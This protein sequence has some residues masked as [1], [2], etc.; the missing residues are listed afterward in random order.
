MRNASLALFALIFPASAVEIRVASFNIGA[1]FGTT[2]FDYSLGDAGTPD[3]DAVR[4]ILGRINADV[5]ALQEIHT[6]DLQGSPDDLDD[7]AAALGYPYLHVT[8][9]T[10]AFDPSLRVV[11]MSRFPFITEADIVSP[12]GARELS[13]LHPVVKVDVPGTT[14]DLVVVS[15]H[16][17]AE[18]SLADRFRRAVEMKRLVAYLGSAGLANDD[19]FVIVGDFNPSSINATFTGL[20][21][22]LPGG[23]VLGSDI[24]FPVSYSTNPLTYFSTPGAVRLDLRQLDGSKSTYGTTS[25]N[26]PALDMILVSPAIAGRL[27]AA[28]VYNSALD[29]GNETGLVKAGSPLAAATS[30]TASDHYA[31]FADLELDSDSPNLDLTISAPSV[32]EG[33]ADGTV[34]ATVTIPAPRPNAVVV[35]LS[36]DDATAAAP[37]AGTLVIPAGAVGGSV[38][39]ATPRNFIADPQRSVTITATA[40]GY[41]PDSAVLQVDDVDG[42]Y[43]FTLPGQ[44]VVENFNGFAGDHEPAPWVTSG[45]LT[46]RG[47]DDGSSA[48][49]GLRAYGA[50][51]DSSLGW[52]PQGV[53]ASA[54]AVFMNQSAVPLTAL[55]ITLDAEQWRGAL[56]GAADGL[57]VDLVVSGQSIPLRGLTF[58]AS[59]SLPDG[60]LAGGLTTTLSA[61]ATG[62]SIPPGGSFELRVSFNPGPGG[63][64]LPSDVFVNEFHYD[65]DGTDDGEFVEIVVGPGFAGRLADIDVALYNGDNATAGVVYDTLNLGSDFTPGGTFNGYRVFTAV[66]PANGLQNGLRDGFAVFDNAHS[67]VLQFISYEGSFAATNGPAS[68]MV[69]TDI[70]LSQNT[71]EVVGQASLGLTGTG[72]SAAGF[73]WRKFTGIAHSPGLANDAQIFSLPVLP[74]Q[75]LAIDNVSVTF[76][77]DHDLDGLPDLFDPD[78]DND[79]QTDVDEGAF[80]SDAFDASSRFTAV[81]ARAVAPPHGLEL[82]FPGARGIRYTV[83]SSTTLSGWKE[84]AS[85]VGNGQT[86]VVPLSSAGS[87]MFFRVRAGD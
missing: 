27:F 22:G 16:L 62:L 25:A 40:G 7:L 55:Q 8:P 42:P 36:P 9:V 43:V 26:G 75:G 69:S 85:H 58:S 84:Q 41:D 86:I 33:S 60:P 30:A 71:T 2:Y 53:A 28:E 21:T 72:G 47:L 6:A 46:W 34:T 17:K 65:N 10:G 18:T 23:F 38:A 3:H 78:D 44:T 79:G 87:R 32:T 20:P 61:S 59:Q 57:S 64:E 77:S 4:G 19:N 39:L 31:V 66:L 56:N 11:I 82:S 37:V 76:L 12:A 51:M 13:R 45:A 70:G 1:H 35:T 54:A 74:S 15:A 14:R 29:V 49:P 50:A 73:T 67:R 63:G 24:A 81:L 48:L 5:V 52:L 68:G 80:G 83:E